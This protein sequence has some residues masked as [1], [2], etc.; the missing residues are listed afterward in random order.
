MYD[1]TAP[2]KSS[3]PLFSRSKL[4][5]NRLRERPRGASWLRLE[6]IE[7]HLIPAQVLDGHAQVG[8]QRI[9]PALATLKLGEVARI[10]RHRFPRVEPALHAIQSR[11]QNGPQRQV[12][13]GGGLD[14]L[15]CCSIPIQDTSSNTFSLRQAD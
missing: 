15:Q 12:G 2:A 7:Q 14:S 3:K 10:D 6:R 5:V 9:D 1:S 4:G 8:W 11:R 13:I